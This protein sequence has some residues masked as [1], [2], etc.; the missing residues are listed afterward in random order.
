MRSIQPRGR[1]RA[2]HAT[3]V[4]AA[5]A[6]AIAGLSTAPARA[7]D[8]AAAEGGGIQEIT[9]TARRREERLQDVPIAVTSFSGARLESVGAEDLT[10]ITQETPNVTLETSRA[11]NT[12][13]TAFI[14]GVGQQDPVAGFE[15]GVGIYLD[16]VYLNRPQ[17]AIIDVYDV[18]RIEVLRGPQGTLYGRNTVGGAVKYVTR[19]LDADDPTLRARVSLG[20]YSQMDGVLSGSMPVTDTFRV[21]GAVASFNRDGFGENLT[22]GDENY[23][24]KLLAARATLEW[25]P[26]ES[27]LVRLAGDY[28]DDDSSPR[29]GYRLLP[30]AST[31][32][33]T[34]LAG[35]FDT[36]AGSTITMP[37]KENTVVA[38]GGQLYAEWSPSDAWTFKSI[39]AYR[40][41]TSD[42][43]IDFDSTAARSFDAPV[44]YTNDQAS[45][46]FQVLFTQDRLAVVGGAYYLDANAYN[47]F[48]VVFGSVT[49]LTVGDVD[50]E[51]WALFG[52]ATYDLSDQW[53][54]TVGGRY[55][56]DKRSS[57]IVRQTFLGVNSPLFGN[58]A[59][60]SVTA[61]VLVNGV[62][63]VPE[64]NGSRTDSDFT[65]RVIVAWQ[66]NAD[67]NLYASYSE[68]FKGGGFDPRGN[69]ANADVRAGFLPETVD[70]YE[71]GLK[72]SL[73]DGRATIN[74][75]VFFADYT[76]VQIP[77]SLVL[78]G[79]P[80]S[81][82]GTVT[83]AGAAEMKGIEVES[84]FQFTDNLSARVSLGYIDAAYTEFLLNGVDVSAQRD[85]QNTPDWTGNASLTYSLPLLSGRAGVTGS[86]SYR[87]ATQQFEIP[88][89]ALDYPAYWLYD[90]S[91]NWTSGDER[92]QLGLHG[93]NLSDERYITAGYNFP[94]AATDNSVLA[95]YGNPRT[96]T[97]TATYR[98]N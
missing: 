24:K 34:L 7:Q 14:R 94:G 46:E 97:L 51:T 61:P 12:T 26:T 33:R 42:S 48:D 69:F 20:Q 44:V 16:D 70:S 2:L 28:T 65:P 87:G 15:Q 36:L 45:Q 59:A 35:R 22:T 25:Q 43:P 23:D 76:D 31:A 56:D 74:T 93:R 5:V 13:L 73:L 9:V 53:S 32:Q 78:P 84:A 68:G 27:L 86:A 64:F 55:T 80:V 75:A 11:T 40:E 6:A 1:V 29:Q 79:P 30:T 89:P 47:K 37:I 82:V 54:L 57:R 91:L 63:V 95:F 50:T 96:V 71:L 39:T 88:I 38:K 72:T 8:S 67:L 3:T 83:N 49:Q 85:V 60:V 41:D 77:G 62:Q 81:F 92:W 10:Y 21:G 18:E 98:F 58:A 52:E 17:G 66:P 4:A 90:V 19:R